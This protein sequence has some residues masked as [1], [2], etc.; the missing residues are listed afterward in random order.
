LLEELLLLLLL[1]FHPPELYWPSTREAHLAHL[2]SP[3]SPT[4]PDL[5]GRMMGTPGVGA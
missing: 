1:L 3:A 5:R 2:R 4:F